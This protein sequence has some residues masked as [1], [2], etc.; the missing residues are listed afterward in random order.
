M[1]DATAEY[2]MGVAYARGQ[3][4]PQDYQQAA[5]WLRKAAEHGVADAEFALGVAYANGQGLPQGS[6]HPSLANYSSG[7]LIGSSCGLCS[8]RSSSA[9][10]L[11]LA[12]LMA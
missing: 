11:Q 12:F 9:P 2:N 7:P 8:L 4:V 6:T 1:G 3:G 5:D 10:L